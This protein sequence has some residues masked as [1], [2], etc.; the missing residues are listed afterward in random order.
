M[1]NE[2][3]LERL[4]ETPAGGSLVQAKESPAIEDATKLAMRCL[5][6]GIIQ[7]WIETHGTA[8]IV[9]DTFIAEFA[10]RFPEYAVW[11]K[12]FFEQVKKEAMP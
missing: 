4:R 8:P 11:R 12:E 2:A 10:E 7:W 1:P 6:E 5:C 3:E 9:P